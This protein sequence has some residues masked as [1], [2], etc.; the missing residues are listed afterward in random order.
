[1][2]LDKNISNRD[3]AELIQQ[4]TDVSVKL[5]LLDITGEGV[6]VTTAAMVEVPEVPPTSAFWYDDGAG[7]GA[8]AMLGWALSEGRAATPSAVGEE[9]ETFSEAGGSVYEVASGLDGEEDGYR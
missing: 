9:D 4:L 5:A 2:L 1:M 7:S 8:G 6:D 3:T